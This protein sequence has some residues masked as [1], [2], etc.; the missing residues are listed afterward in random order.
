MEDLFRPSCKS[1]Q[2]K[3]SEESP[4]LVLDDKCG[5]KGNNRTLVYF[6]ENTVNPLF[7]NEGFNE[8]IAKT[9]KSTSEIVNNHDMINY[10]NIKLSRFSQHEEISKSHLTFDSDFESGNLLKV[11]QHNEK[12]FVLVLREDYSN[13]KYSHWFYFSVQPS[14]PLE[15]TFHIVNIQKQD[16]ALSEGMQ[17]VAKI[18]NKWQRTGKNITFRKNCKFL[19][20]TNGLKAFA[21]SFSF[22]FSSN[23]KIFFAYSYPFTYSDLE[24]SLALY[25]KCKEK[26]CKI[27]NVC[28]SLSGLDVPVVTITNNIN[29]DIKN[30]KVV[31]FIGRVHP[32]E[33]PSSHIV[34]GMMSF[35][36]SKHEEAEKL[37]NI[38][39]FVIIPMINPDGVKYG[40]SRCSLLGVDLNRRWTDPILALHPE[41]HSVKQLIQSLNEKHKIFLICD[42]HS[43][44][45][46]KNV[47]MYGCNSK[48]SGKSSKE[49]NFKAKIVPLLLSKNNSHFSLKDSHFK[50]DKSKESTARVVMFKQFGIVNSYTIETSFFGSEF[51]KIFEV[52]DWEKIGQDIAKICFQFLLALPLQNGLSEEKSLK[53]LRK[54]PS[55]MSPK[56]KMKIARVDGF[57]SPYFGKKERLPALTERK[58]RN[59][60]RVVQIDDRLLV[61]PFSTNF[62]GR[63][64]TERKILPVVKS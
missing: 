22:E 38:F 7:S 60:R 63:R 26:Y 4:L 12:E 53:N 54:K 58:T 44:A 11:Y 30:K 10:Y 62:E 14:K 18:D 20:Y 40:N 46:K 27:E 29:S 55:V 42:I 9:L 61:R 19:N 17:I 50:M 23:S 45:K 39:V 3:R 49:I 34:S 47:F 35:L 25:K 41:V 32:C 52:C 2:F 56:G 15:V 57:V 48:K 6:N 36:L 59:R 28:K 13:Q 33:A 5:S 16:S 43:H 51:Q 1:F 64:E 37:R 31:V 24:K 21:L 8:S